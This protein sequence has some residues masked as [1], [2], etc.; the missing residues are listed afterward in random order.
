MKRR[1]FAAEHDAFRRSVRTFLTKE[2]DPHYE[3]WEK[4]G[5]VSR[6]AWLAAGRQGLLGMAVPEE[7]GGGGNADFRYSA[8]LAEE[9][10]RAG[11]AGL[12]LGRTASNEAATSTRSARSPRTRPSSSSTTYASPRRICSASSTARSSI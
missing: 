10:A 5:V 9:F 7:Y 1:I 12:A 4:D 8:V 6:D 3:Q 2:V 11:V